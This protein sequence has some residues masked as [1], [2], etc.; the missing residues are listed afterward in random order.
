MYGVAEAP[1][2]FDLEDGAHRCRAASAAPPVD[3]NLEGVS[4]GAP[5]MRCPP[6][7]TDLLV[8]P[9]GARWLRPQ[10]KP[11]GVRF[12][13]QAQRATHDIG[14]WALPRGRLR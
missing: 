13:Q 1:F 4:G 8:P 3:P 6:P 5:P 12:T 10:G 9:S 11:L 2:R 7:P 14:P